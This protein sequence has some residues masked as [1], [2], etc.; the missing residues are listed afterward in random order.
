MILTMRIES[1]KAEP[2]RGGRFWI[3]LEDGSRIPLY[4][5]TV[6][7]FGL[8]VGKEL[9]EDER[10]QLQASASAMSAKMRAVRIVAASAVSKKDL[11]Q[12]LVQKG[13]DPEQ[14]AQA[15]AWMEELR[16]VDDADT[17]RQVVA[18][19]IAKGYGIQRAKQALFEKKIPKQ[20]WEDVLADYPEQTHHIQTF[21]RTRLDSHSDQ[22]EVKRAIDALLRR[23]HSYSQIRLALQRMQMDPDE[24]PEE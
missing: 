3:M 20:Y 15:V 14:A 21:L 13:E 11:Q 18:R 23:G 5:Q 17:A 12:R 4:R 16:L 1:I 8:Y 6:E 9:T 2:D 19:C 22:K 24:F 7:E 10:K